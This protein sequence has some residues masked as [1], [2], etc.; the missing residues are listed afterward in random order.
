MLWPVEDF[1]DGLALY[2]KKLFVP[3]H[4]Q[5]A[6]STKVE[7][8]RSSTPKLFNPNSD[9]DSKFV[10]KLITSDKAH[11]HF[12]RF[13]NKQNCQIWGLKKPRNIRPHALHLLKWTACCDVML[14]RIIGP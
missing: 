8:H 10:P 3:L 1:S 5:S 14:E 9:E 2:T 12:N 4:I 13:V 11:F 7:V 6:I